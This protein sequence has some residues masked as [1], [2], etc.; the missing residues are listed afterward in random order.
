ME[1]PKGYEEFEKEDLVCKLKK[2]LY[3]LKQSSRCWSRTFR[4]SMESLNFKQSQADPCIF[5]KRSEANKL[6]IVAIYVDDLIIIATTEEEMDWIKASLSKNFK[7][8]DMSSPHFCL[9]VNIEQSEGVRLSQKQYIEK[10]VERYGL[11][12]ANPVSTPMDLNVKLTADDGHSK[13]VDNVRYQSMV[14]L[15]YTSPS[16]RDGLLSRMPSSA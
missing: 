11:Q 16:P 14:C 7:M 8:K 5:I 13:P 3:G 12:D 9:G 4:E 10:L 2:S 1:Q 6:T 15:L